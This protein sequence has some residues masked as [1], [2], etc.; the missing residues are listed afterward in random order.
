MSPF[1]PEA[2]DRA[3][4]VRDEIAHNAKL[5]LITNGSGLLDQTIFNLL[6]DAACGPMKLDIWLKLD[7]GTPNWY[8]KVNRS[9]VPYEK[10]IAQ[11][12]KFVRIAPLIIQTMLCTVDGEA[13]PAEEEEAWINL[14]QELAG[15]A[16]TVAAESKAA[17]QLC[18]INVGIRKVQIYGKA[19]PAPEDPKTD[20][21]P[22]RC[23]EER[24]ARLVA[25]LPENIPVEVFP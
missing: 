4:R 21:L 5:V 16:L 24:A 10:L 9:E 19:R 22:L 8:E 3:N 18:A 7:A 11:I 25:A 14:M 20:K 1:F 2:L 13:P 15:S 12:R 17:G 6:R 23:L